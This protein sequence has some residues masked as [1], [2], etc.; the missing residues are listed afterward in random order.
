MSDFSSALY[1]LYASIGWFPMEISMVALM[2][3]LSIPFIVLIVEAIGR[4]LV[5]GCRWAFGAAS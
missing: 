1:D 4:T 3:V 5:A 2:A